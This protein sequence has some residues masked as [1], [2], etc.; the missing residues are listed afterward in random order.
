MTCFVG[1]DLENKEIEKNWASQE[2]GE[3]VNSVIFSRGE[4]VMPLIVL[5]PTQ[6]N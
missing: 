3:S 6:D 1:I 2:L 4:A 5:E